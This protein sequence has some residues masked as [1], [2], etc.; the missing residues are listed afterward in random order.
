M[1]QVY[2][3]TRI[4]FL[5]FAA[6]VITG[7]VKHPPAAE[8]VSSPPVLTEQ[9][10]RKIAVARVN[11]VEL[12]LDALEKMTNI[13]SANTSTNLSPESR[14]EIRNK[15]L[16]QLVLRE[17]VLQQAS[18]KGWKVGARDVSHA[19]DNFIMSL[20]HEE[21]FKNYLEKQN[22]TEEEVRKQIEK[23]LL[24]QLVFNREVLQ[25]ISVSDDDM[26]KEYEQHG[27]RYGTPERRMSFEEAKN[28]I[29]KKLRAEAQ[30][31][32]IEE[33]ERE[34]KRD[35]KVEVLDAPRYPEQ[36]RP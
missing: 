18:R 27:D 21:G 7:C 10:M 1:K 29:E 23:S 9:E 26:R 25:K 14:K 36:K 17:L 12:Y 28:V 32:R 20:G 35:A 31:R 6:L 30:Q 24:L 16:D 33:W 3:S 15:A 2:R 19:M 13:M 11:G 4:L 34:L 8:G 22:T 5:F